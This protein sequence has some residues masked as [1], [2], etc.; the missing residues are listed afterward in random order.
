MPMGRMDSAFACSIDIHGSL[1][2]L[3]D[4]LSPQTPSSL[5]AVARQ[6][7]TGTERNHASALRCVAELHRELPQIFLAVIRNQSETSRGVD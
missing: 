5:F 2:R 6:S 3:S 7:S 1:D 4:T